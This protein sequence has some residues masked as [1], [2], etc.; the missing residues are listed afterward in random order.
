MDLPPQGTAQPPMPQYE[1]QPASLPT[2]TRV[3]YG[4]LAAGLLAIV[5][6]GAVVIGVVSGRLIAIGS[7]TPK[8]ESR[9]VSGFTQVVLSGSGT[10][11]L[12]QGDSESL[13]V[14]ADD[15][16]LANVQTTVSGGRLTL[17]QRGVGLY[18]PR[19]PVHYDLTVKDLTAVEISGSGTA[20]ATSLHTAGLRL[21]ISGSGTLA[22]GGISVTT[23]DT[24]ISG[25]GTVTVVG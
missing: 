22:F 16:L 12:R 3:L 7:G 19:V 23:L 8:T 6:I 1:R 25:S 11:S 4:C 20:T 13:K 5:V 15:N 14:T 2:A 18:F 10:L 21:Q 24:S 17:G 9:A